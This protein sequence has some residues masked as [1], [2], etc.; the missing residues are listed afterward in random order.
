[1]IKLKMH[2]GNWR[3]EIDSEVLEF[4][5]KKEFE[6]FL[7]KILEIKDKFGRIKK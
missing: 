5:T 7:N 1:M 6:G 4:K 2:E 3:I